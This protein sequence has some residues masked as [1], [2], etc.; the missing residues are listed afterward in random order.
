MKSL[1]VETVTAE[2]LPPPVVPAPKPTG[3]LSAA[4]ACCGRASTARVAAAAT[5]AARADLG[6]CGRERR[7]RMRMLSLRKGWVGGVYETE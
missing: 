4:P 3:E 6:A 1:S 5:A 7:V 2:A